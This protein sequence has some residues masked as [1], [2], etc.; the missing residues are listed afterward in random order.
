VE[1]QR[2]TLVAVVEVE[3]VAQSLLVERV[4]KVS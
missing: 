4:A 3:R 2:Q 1:M